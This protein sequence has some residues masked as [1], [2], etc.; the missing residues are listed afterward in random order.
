[1]LTF[2]SQCHIGTLQTLLLNPEQILDDASRIPRNHNDPLLR[3]ARPT[4]VARDYQVGGVLLL[5]MNP[6][7]GTSSHQQISYPSDR[8]L[9]DAIDQMVRKRDLVSYRYWRDVAQPKAMETWRIW[10]VSIKGILHSLAAGGITS[11]QIA[12]G[13]LMPFRS[14]GN[15][16]TASEF[17][18]A[19]NSDLS[20][21][22]TLLKPQLIVKMSASFPSFQKYV[23]RIEILP[24][25]RGIGDGAITSLGRTDLDNIR[26][27]AET[28]LIPTQTG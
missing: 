4:W 23:A 14:E 13:N 3:I 1:M 15:S 28:C 9:A 6:A 18:R 17:V 8:G 5:G 16:V 11:N 10:K 26:K 27:W 25:R 19:W 24:F 2:E 12:F 20:H 21:V 22:I 7:G